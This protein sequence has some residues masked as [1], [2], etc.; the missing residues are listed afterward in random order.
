MQWSRRCRHLCK[1]PI[2]HEPFVLDESD[3]G[4]SFALRGLVEY[5]VEAA[6][7]DD[8]DLNII[9]VSA[10]AGYQKDFDCSMAKQTL[11]NCD[12]KSMPRT[13]LFCAAD[14]ATYSA[15]TMNADL[16][17]AIGLC[18]EQAAVMSTND[19]GR[20]KNDVDSHVFHISCY[21]SC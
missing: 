19:C 16:S 1:C 13:A 11:K 15:S 5:D 10:T 14:P 18:D 21:M 7:F 20:E 9:S 12:P 3:C 8:S 4:G 2:A 6:S 17:A